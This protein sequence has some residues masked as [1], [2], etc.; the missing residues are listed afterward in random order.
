LLDIASLFVEALCESYDGYDFHAIGDIVTG[1][2]PLDLESAKDLC[3]VTFNTKQAGPQAPAQA[4]LLMPCDKLLPVAKAPAKTTENL[5]AEDV[6]K[7]IIG[8]LHRMRVSLTTQ[9]GSGTLT[10]AEL[11]SLSINDILMLDAPVSEPVKL[12]V[13]G[14]ELFK[15]QL[16]KS[17]GK[18]AVVIAEP[19]AAV[20]RA[21]AGVAVA[22]LANA[23]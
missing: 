9:L 5:S 4:Y 18:Y 11:M 23:R 14:L 22:T 19:A 20:A 2:L 8:H 7:A 12:I 15:G 17:A 3:K 1:Q 13:Q 6:S 16:A 10:F 21:A